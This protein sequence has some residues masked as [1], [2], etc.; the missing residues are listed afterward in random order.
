MLFPVNR[1]QSPISTAS[2]PGQH[3]HPTQASQPAPDRGELAIVREVC[4]RLVESVST[5]LDLQYGLILRIECGP[6]CGAG[7]VLLGEP[8]VMFSRPRG[9]LVVDEPLSQQQF[10]QPM[11]GT[12]Q[13]A[14]AVFPGPHQIP[15]GFLIG[16]GDRDR[17][18]LIQPQ[19]PGQVHGVCRVGLHRIPAG[20]CSFDG[21]ATTQRTPAAV[22]TTR[23]PSGLP[24]MRPRSGPADPAPIPE[25]D[26]CPAAASPETTRL[27]HINRRCRDGTSMHIQSNTRTLSE[28]GASHNCRIGRADHLHP[29][30]HE[31]CERGPVP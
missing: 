15:C 17:G 14:P 25:S 19:Q 24:H 20:I 11:T 13:I 8:P 5:G 22:N 30:T 27:S 18:D 9:T 3:A 21:A 31:F 10:A 23:T 26:R 2:D 12:H 4:D 1:V 28:H 6:R 7:Q 29:V 16:R